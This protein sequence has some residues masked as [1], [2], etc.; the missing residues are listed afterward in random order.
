MENASVTIELDTIDQQIV[1]LLRED[2]RMTVSVIAKRIDI[3]ETTAR[4]R[5]QRLIQNESIKVIA[6]PNPEKLGKP[7]IL[8]VS[9]VVENGR[10]DEVAD[11]FMQMDEVRYVAILTGRFHIMVDVFFGA[12]S[13]LLVFFE[14]FQKIPGIISYESQFIL[15]LLKAEYKY[16]LG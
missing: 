3:P 16:T 14:K 13:E 8:I 7:N 12:H 2:G 11:A 5:V 6:W 15:D 1:E 9:I 4:Y 10:V